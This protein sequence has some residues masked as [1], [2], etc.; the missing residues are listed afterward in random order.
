M[1]FGLVQVQNSSEY[2][3]PNF[4]ILKHL[5]FILGINIIPITH[6]SMKLILLINVKMPMTVGILTK[7]LQ[8]RYNRVLKLDK[9]LFFTIY[10]LWTI[11]I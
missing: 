1:E 11:E 4:L 10:R 5:Q 9:S 2:R 7:Y 8:Y 3:R 6:L